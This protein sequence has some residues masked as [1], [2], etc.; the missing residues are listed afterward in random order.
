MPRTT[1]KHIADWELINLVI[2]EKIK[3]PTLKIWGNKRRKG[4]ESFFL[5]STKLYFICEVWGRHTKSVF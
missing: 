2:K 3:S 5:T 1:Y 4:I